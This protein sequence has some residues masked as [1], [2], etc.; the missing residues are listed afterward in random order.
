M[1]AQPPQ[2]LD[3]LLNLVNERLAAG[4][5]NVLDPQVLAAILIL[6]DEEEEDD[7]PHA[8]VDLDALPPER[9]VERFRLDASGVRRLADALGLPP[10]IR[11][12]RH[13]YVAGRDEAMC[14]LLRRLAAPCRWA[15]LEPEF[16][17]SSSFLCA[18]FLHMIEWVD[19]RYAARMR[20]NPIALGPRIRAYADAVWRARAPLKTCFGFIEGTAM[21]VCRPCRYRREAYSGQKR[22]HCLKFQSV[23][24]P[25]G[26]IADLSGPSAG[27]Y[28]N[29]EILSHS[30]LE[31]R[32][33]D[34]V[35]DK[36]VIYG[37]EGYTYSQHV[38]VPFRKAALTEIERAFND[39]M[40]VL[41]TS[42]KRGFAR[43]TQLFSLLSFVPALRIY[44]SPVAKFYRVAVLLTNM[45]TC[46]SGT[47][48]VATY[49]GVLPPS[50]DE[51]MSQFL[52]PAQ[53]S[54]P[55][56]R[57]RQDDERARQRTEEP[58]R[59]AAPSPP[60]ACCT[61]AV[62]ARSR[63]TSVAAR[64]GRGVRRRPVSAR[65]AGRSAQRAST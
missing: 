50:L 58:P 44:S 24:L 9:C 4:T 49:F 48:E 39:R 32:L 40:A 64:P 13:G 60:Q 53:S 31:E 57:P 45:I 26:I 52:V 56:A 3:A 55:V 11:E 10:E 14:I 54:D 61:P 62:A 15:D 19:E 7:I 33:A 25:D 47:S 30:G 36:H 27:C 34:A 2:D 8:I 51:Y 65:R 35:F 21:Q 37:D 59:R 12:D 6:A 1:D 28:S 63:A 41:L 29:Q 23:Q 22:C 43:V 38:A 18:I 20:L 42:A 46:H 16:G 17:R 5:L